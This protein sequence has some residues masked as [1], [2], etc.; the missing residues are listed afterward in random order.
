MN[1]LEPGNMVGVARDSS[2]PGQSTVWAEEALFGHRLWPRQTPW[3]LFLEFL[4]VVEAFDRQMPGT[5]FSPSPPDQMRPYRMRFRMGLRS[6][7][8]GNDEMERIA[9]ASDDSDQQWQ[10]WLATME[11]SGVEGGF[12]Y[13]R[14]RF[15]RFRDFAELVSLIRQT[16]LENASNR[17]SS[18][19]FVFPFGVDALY[20][21]AIYKSSGVTADFNN[22]GRTGEILYMMASRAQRAAEL[23]E[24]FKRL[25]DPETP[26]NRLVAR[27]SAPGDET[28]D[29]EHKGETYLPYRTH[30]AFDRLVEDWL[31]VFALGLPEQDAFAHLVPL[32]ALHVLLYQLETAA[33]I[34]GRERRPSLVC[35]LIAPRREFVRQRAIISF[36]DNDSL[37]LRALDATIDA[38]VAGPAWQSLLA[39][40]IADRERSERALD[41]I[42]REFWYE[43]DAGGLSSPAD[44]VAR[45]REE[46]EDKHEDVGGGVH[47]AYSRY[48]GLA[49]SRGTNRTRYAPNDA[50]LKT[51]VVTRVP[52]RM[53]FKRFLADLHR[54]YGLVI[55]EVEA[56]E[57][58]TGAGF[59]SAA[60]ERNRTRLEGRL[61]SMGLLQRLSD[62]CAYVV[63]PFAAER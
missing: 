45:M 20:C 3:L 6:I 26:K 4:N 25:L 34:A 38:F 42:A 55:G 24:P 56:R 27:L 58:I 62:G 2:A 16:T 13:L 59:D 61:A 48:V 31:A 32:G 30:P 14:S 60:F 17:R 9:A 1:F 29:R 7:L 53:E 35:E 43:D 21:D 11:G 50:L 22:F 15:S 36:Q 37:P 23:R 8:F 51:L 52:G 47:A 19:R 57:E 28:A 10:E 5:L 33:A 54:Q 40:E 63:N 44:I 18:S 41:L 39:E 12:G 49:S 46:V